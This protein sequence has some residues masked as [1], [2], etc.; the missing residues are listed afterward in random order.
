MDKRAFFKCFFLNIHYVY[1]ALCVGTWYASANRWRIQ[2][3][4]TVSRLVPRKEGDYVKTT[5][6][7]NRN[8]NSMKKGE[9]DLKEILRPVS[10]LVRSMFIP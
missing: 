5:L 10:V 7:E 4:R 3:A 8:G 1:S 2:I 9:D 6:N